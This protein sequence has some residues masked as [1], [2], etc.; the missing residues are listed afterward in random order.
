MTFWKEYTDRN[1]TTIEEVDELYLKM[2]G[3]SR[4]E[5]LGYFIRWCFYRESKVLEVG[6][7]IGTQ[8][9]F[10]KEMGFKYLYGIDSEPYAVENAHK[11]LNIIQGDATDTPF[12]DGY[13]DYVMTNGLLIHIPPENI[14][15]VLDEIYRCSRRYILCYEYYSEEYDIIKYRGHD[16]MLWKADFARLFLKRFN[17][18]HIVG[19]N[20]ED[21]L[22]QQYK[23]NDGNIDTMFLLEKS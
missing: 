12:K 15:A 17:D 14:N 19:C 21:T 11:G 4:T 6:C 2:Y 18:L 5:M 7:N 13:F 1:P 9:L 23:R 16:N 8:L 3:I 10:L 22:I 20:N